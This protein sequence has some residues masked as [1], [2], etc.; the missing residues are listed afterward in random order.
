[1]R[2]SRREVAQKDKVSP[3]ASKNAFGNAVRLATKLNDRATKI[4]EA[5]ASVAAKAQI[6]NTRF[7]QNKNAPSTKTSGDMEKAMKDLKKAQEL[8]KRL[9]GEAFRSV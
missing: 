2:Q 8:Q 1:M 9:E 4:E 7:A 5:E 3:N 6:Y